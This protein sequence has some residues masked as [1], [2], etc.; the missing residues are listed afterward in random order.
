[1]RPLSKVADMLENTVG[2]LK[3]YERLRR[4]E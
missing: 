2:E 3:P 4:Q 1:M